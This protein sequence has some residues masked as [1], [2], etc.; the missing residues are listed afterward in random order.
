MGPFF[1]KSLSFR[2]KA[3]GR[4]S[5]NPDS[6]FNAFNDFNFSPCQWDERS[7]TDLWP[8]R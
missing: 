8:G 5:A 7:A 6:G 1:A 3:N 2:S 4:C